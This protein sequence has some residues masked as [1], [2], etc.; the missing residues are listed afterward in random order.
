MIALTL[1][2]VVALWLV[3][4]SGVNSPDAVG[5]AVGVLLLGVVVIEVVFVCVLWYGSFRLEPVNRPKDE[6]EDF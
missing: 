1:V 3:Y 6:W 4:E 5:A 2:I